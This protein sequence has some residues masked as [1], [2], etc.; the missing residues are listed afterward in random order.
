MVYKNSQV[1]TPVQIILHFVPLIFFQDTILF[2]NESFN[3]S[4]DIM[5]TC[6]EEWINAHDNLAG[7]LA[8]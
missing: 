8:I 5:T 2:L 3:D 4:A 7:S 6:D 1:K